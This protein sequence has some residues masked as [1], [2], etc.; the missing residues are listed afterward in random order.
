[1]RGF[2]AGAGQYVLQVTFDPAALPVRCDRFTRRTPSQSP[3]ET[4]ELTL[5]GHHC[6]HLGAEGLPPCLLGLRWDWE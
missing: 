3:L 2:N 1:M 6:A 5:D 4:E